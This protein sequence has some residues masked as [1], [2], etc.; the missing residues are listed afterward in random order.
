M[1]PKS[2]ASAPYS[3][4]SARAGEIVMLYLCH[5]VDFEHVIGP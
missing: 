3:S 2:I 1:Q 4:S 5:N